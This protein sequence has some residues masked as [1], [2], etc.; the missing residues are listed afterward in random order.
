MMNSG[1]SP[2]GFE[3]PHPWTLHFFFRAMAMLRRTFLCAAF[4]SLAVFSTAPD[5]ASAQKGGGGGG[6]GGSVGGARPGGSIGGARPG[7]ISPGVR[8]GAVTP[9]V[10]PG[11]PAG[12]VRPSMGTTHPGNMHPN[13]SQYHNH[14]HNHNN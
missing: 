4:L 13:Y 7:G 11:V 14:N 3:V 12:S 6:R 8:P 1:A 2:Q 9:S 5:F 10:R